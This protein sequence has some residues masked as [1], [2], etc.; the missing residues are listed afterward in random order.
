MIRDYSVVFIGQSYANARPGI[1]VTILQPESIKSH[2]YS[3][4]NGSGESKSLWR[5]NISKATRD[6]I[7]LS[8]FVHWLLRIQIK[9]KS[10]QEVYRGFEHYTRQCVNVYVG[11]WK[12]YRSTEPNSMRR[13]NVMFDSK[14]RAQQE[15]FAVFCFVFHGGRY[16]LTFYCTNSIFNSNH[17]VPVYEM[18]LNNRKTT[19]SSDSWCEYDILIPSDF[20][21]DGVG[22]I[23]MDAPF[24]V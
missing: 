24:S 2:A 19:D 21:V 13:F 3:H 22:A 14:W 9:R 1:K 18:K 20:S 15:K 10:L 12:L 4:W 5:E 7:A 17:T 8:I 23:W 6:L 16:V 11:F